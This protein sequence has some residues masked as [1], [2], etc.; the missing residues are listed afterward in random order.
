MPSANISASS[1]YTSAAAADLISNYSWD[2]SNASALHAPSRVWQ[3]SEQPE[4]TLKPDSA[5][6][7]VAD[8]VP[9]PAPVHEQ[10]VGR[11][12]LQGTRPVPESLPPM[13]NPAWKEE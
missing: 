5:L 12:S 2:A 1:S 11:A 8:P 3:T 10:D 13:Y 9:E 7:V 6:E 4:P